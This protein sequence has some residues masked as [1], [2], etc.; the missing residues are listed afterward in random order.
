MKLSTLLEYQRMF[1]L[2]KRAELLCER[3]PEDVFRSIYPIK[4]KFDLELEDVLAKQ[5]VEVTNA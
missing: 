3:L 1:N 5:E 4:A 2:L